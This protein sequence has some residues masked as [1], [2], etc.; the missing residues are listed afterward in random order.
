MK[1]PETCHS[2]A[3]PTN[4]TGLF[5]GIGNN[6]KVGSYLA[7]ST[8][9]WYWFGLGIVVLVFI[10][11]AVLTWRKCGTV[12]GDI[13][14]DLY[15]SWR[16]SH[17]AVL[18]RDLFFFS[19]GPFSQYFDALLFRIFGASILTIVISNLAAAAL[20]LFILFRR[21]AA[22]A[23]TSTAV[24]ISLAFIIAFAF[25]YYFFQ[26]CNYLAPYSEETVH[27]FVLAI[28]GI[29]FL[30]DWMQKRRLYA[31]FLAGLCNGLVFLTK[32]DI[33]LALVVTD[34][35]AIGVLYF[36]YRETRFG[37]KSLAAFL[38]AAMIPLLFFF[39]YFL[40]VENWRDSLRSV[41][42]AWV[43]VF[44]SAVI[45]QPFYQWCTGMDHPYFHLKNILFQSV[46]VIAVTSFY[47][48][49]FRRIKT[50]E[51]DWTRIQQRTAPVVAPTLLI[52]IYADHWR[53]TGELVSSSFMG[54]LACL[55]LL[56]AGGFFLI[57]IVAV[58][59]KPE[60]YRSPWAVVLML[61]APLLAA[62]YTA[63]WI[64]CGYS[65]PLL[66]VV[67][68]GLIYWNRQLLVKQQ[69][70]IFPFLWSVFALVLLSKMGLFPRIY[71]Y[72][73]V[74]AMPAFVAGIYCL[75]WL[76][77]LL[78]EKGWQVPARYFRGTVCI[79]LTAGLW[80]LFQQ[81]ARNY[82]LQNVAVGS[83]DDKMFASSSVER[84]NAYNAALDWVR[85][86][87]P[88]NATLAVLPQAPM[89]NFLTG[90]INPTPCV[91]WD[92]IA[93]SIFGEAKMTAAFE[94]SPPDYV[95]LVDRKVLVDSGDLGSPG[96]GHDVMQW[97]KQNYQA[98]VLFGTEPL[99]SRQFGIEILKRLPV[100]SGGLSRSKS[101]RSFGGRK[102]I[103]TAKEAS[104]HPNP[105][106][107]M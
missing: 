99:K 98:Q 13:G 26:G 66:A 93:I 67:S 50:R 74:L 6:S 30:A 14:I 60:I 40:R 28:L 72:G 3:V 73:F 100:Q 59:W 41:G 22:A 77:P 57:N 36:I 29:A 32:P 71:H 97:I 78:L 20:T 17:G 47:V 16:L 2:A 43:P 106:C 88:R 90:R 18:Y 33:F 83:G 21:F 107:V 58:N 63:N 4:L 39:F 55:W 44:N 104:V 23:D 102:F 105:S 46:L 27:G 101:A 96:Y 10:A 86:N 84:A 69:K 85:T 52:L 49:A 9:Q 15:N 51:Q 25:P 11:E 62:A 37:L 34:V 61:L 48:A 42:F 53:R 91:F 54:M 79:V 80:T 56:L 92:Q 45:K 75:F 1:N 65:L 82:S 19:G 31:A 12:S 87:V 81:S 35:A 24:A 70:F 103:P 38:A 68:C 76:L 89:I 7:L 8:R 94:K 95:V 64:D 5:T